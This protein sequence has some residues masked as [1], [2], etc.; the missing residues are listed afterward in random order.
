MLW[1]EDFKPLWKVHSQN[2][3]LLQGVWLE[4]NFSGW[5]YLVPICISTINVPRVQYVSVAL[6]LRDA[7]SFISLADLHSK[8]L[9]WK[10]NDQW[11]TDDP[12]QWFSA[13]GACNPGG[14]A[15]VARR[16]VER[17]CVAEMIWKIAIMV[18]Y[19]YILYCV[20]RRKVITQKALQTGVIFT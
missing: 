19:K 3:A 14:I 2:S 4:I 5:I 16:Y 17:L 7:D 12:H 9:L 8:P 20:F 18:W 6:V 11:N 1:W 15:A 13:R 10:L